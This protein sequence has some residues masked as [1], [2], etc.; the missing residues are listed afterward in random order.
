MALII[1]FNLSGDDTWLRERILGVD[2]PLP[3]G[4]QRVIVEDW[5]EADRLQAKMANLCHDRRLPYGGS[6]REVWHG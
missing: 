6:I 3:T 2:A 1:T 4:L 5:W